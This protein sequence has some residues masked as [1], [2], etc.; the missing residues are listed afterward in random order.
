M[1]DLFLILRVFSKLWYTFGFEFEM[2]L[3]PNVLDEAK[4]RDIDI[5]SQIHPNRCI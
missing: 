1:S 4:S 2:G 3:F 5:A